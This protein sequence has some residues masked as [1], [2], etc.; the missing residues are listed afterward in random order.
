MTFREPVDLAA[1]NAA[2]R[3]T[4]IAHLGIVFTEAGPDWLR[5]TMPVDARTR[6]PYGLLHGGASMVLAETL[7]S[8][9]GN[10]CVEAGQLCVG[11]EINANHL[12]S[13]RTGT[14]TGT[15]RPLHLGRTSQ[16][17]EIRIEDAAG[18]PVC[19]SRLTLA[20]IAGN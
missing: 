6:Q 17:W 12:R 4:L 14:V 11:M 1:L 3:D 20:V 13:A 9:A 19:V 16:V 2:A 5:A 15:A 10:L 8:G 7:G 18:K